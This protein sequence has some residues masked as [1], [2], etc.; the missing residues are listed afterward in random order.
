MINKMSIISKL[1]ISSLAVLLITTAF[2]QQNSVE[3]IKATCQCPNCNL[4]GLNLKKYKP[5]STKQSENPLLKQTNSQNQ[6]SCNIKC[7][8]SNAN[9]IHANLE[10]SNFTTCIRGYVTP[11]SQ[12]SFE[13]AELMSANLSDSKFYGVSFKSANLSHADLSDTKLFLSDFSYANLTGANLSD[14]ESNPDAM[15]GWGSNFSNAN[16][17]GANLEDAKLYGNFQGANFAHANLDE[18]TISTSQDA[19]SKQVKSPVEYWQG[20]NF[21][22]SDISKTKFMVNNGGKV[23]LNGAIF[24]HT[25]LP[26]GK[27]INR[28]C[29]RVNLNK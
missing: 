23:D 12:V 10:D 16:F 7:D 15:H 8:F 25:K 20:V 4:E 18:A 9:L 28:D 22:Y 5:G 6:Q 2:A 13:S 29:D 27:I 14:A 21:S 24:C 19:L 26:S 3:Q 17:T 11:I 1:V